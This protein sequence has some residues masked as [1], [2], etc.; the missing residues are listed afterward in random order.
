[1]CLAL[2]L[3]YWTVG[4]VVLQGTHQLLSQDSEVMDIVHD[5]LVMVR[6]CRWA[7]AYVQMQFC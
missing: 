4:C 2:A 6:D 5:I 1:M 7:Y 3:S